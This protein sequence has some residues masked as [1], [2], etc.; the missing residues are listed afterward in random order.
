MFDGLFVAFVVLLPLMQVRAQL[1]PGMLT[2]ADAVF[3]CALLAGIVAVASGELKVISTPLNPWLFTYIAVAGLSVVWSDSPS[4]SAARLLI[5]MYLVL[6]AIVSSHAVS[7]IS[8]VKRVVM[9]WLGGTAITVMA[10][11]LGVILFYSRYKPLWRAVLIDSYGSL[12]PGDYPRVHGL[13][14]NMNMCCDYLI[15]SFV[16]LV[17]SRK[18]GWIKGVV[19]ALFIVGICITAVFT[20]SPGLGGL[21]LAMGLWFWRERCGALGRMALLS[22]IVGASAFLAACV[23]PPIR[24]G[25]PEWRVPIINRN[26]ESSARM[27]C[28]TAAYQTWMAHPLLGRGTGLE[29]PCPAYRTASGETQHLLD[30]HNTYLNTLATKGAVGFFALLGIVASVLWPLNGNVGV[31]DRNMTS[32]WNALRIALI[33]TFLY[34][35]FTGSF[36]HTRHQWVL[37]GLIGGARTNVVAASGLISPQA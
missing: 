36:E 9:A 26:M 1:A 20:V 11:V 30:A 37:I 24:S 12:P 22:G 6:I 23:V 3:L 16:L 25:S 14:L 10:G 17:M 18:M 4:R 32:A 8:A 13:F 34:D 5:E 21:L 15:C 28:W 35:G 19:F 27:L 31:V 7:S 33:C 2:V 29:V